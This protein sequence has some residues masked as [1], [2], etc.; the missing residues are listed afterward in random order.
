M[1]M[2][3][4]NKIIEEMLS[5]S[6]GVSVYDIVSGVF[7]FGS[8]LVDL[9]QYA[10]VASSKAG[11]VATAV[12]ETGSGVVGSFF[13][14]IG[15]LFGSKPPTLEELVAECLK[16]LDT[17]SH[18]YSVKKVGDDFYTGIG[19]KIKDYAQG[20]NTFKS[21]HFNKSGFKEPIYTPDIKFGSF[22]YDA[23]DFN[24]FPNTTSLVS[25]KQSYDSYILTN[26][27][28]IATINSSISTIN[29][30]ITTIE[31]SIEPIKDIAQTSRTFQ[32]TLIDVSSFD[33]YSM[34]FV[35]EDR[36]DVYTATDQLLNF[37]LHY[38]DGDTI[39]IDFSP[40]IQLL[41]CLLYTS[42]AADE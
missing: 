23:N 41:S 39:I 18:S 1:Q 7:T 5:A 40:I 13:E 22:Q 30:S 37:Q 31:T 28:S 24:L 34:Y 26:N 15:D 32:I 20:N 10:M 16:D 27:S 14:G 33:N 25:F 36:N 4:I 2:W 21:I 11:N 3:L 9:H 38:N 19:D 6:G 29:S 35:G 8:V 42:D 12:V 17:R